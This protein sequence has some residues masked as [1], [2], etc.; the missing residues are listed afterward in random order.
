MGRSLC[1][2]MLSFSCTSLLGGCGTEANSS[3]APATRPVSVSVTALKAQSET[4]S[5]QQLYSTVSR[6]GSSNQGGTVLTWSAAGAGSVTSDGLFACTGLGSAAVTARA[7]SASATT[8]TSCLNSPMPLA[9]GVFIEHSLDFAGPFSSWLNVK[10]MYGAK[11]DGVSDDTAALQAALT[12]QLHMKRVI[13]LPRG[14]YIISDTL[15]VQG[16][17]GLTIIGEDPSNTIIKWTGPQGGTMLDAEGCTWI[18]ISRLTLDGNGSAG[19]GEHISSSNV[20]GFYPTF[21]LLSDQTI[22]NLEVGIEVGSAGE[23]TVERIHFDNDSG[24]GVSQESYNALNF[25]VRD[26]LF[27]E[28]GIGI[29]NA[30]NKD[31]AGGFNVTNSVFVDSKTADMAIGATGPFSIRRSLSVGSHAF[32]TTGATGAPALITFQA[33]TIISP[34]RIPIQIGT[35]SPIVL[36]DNAFA[37]MHSDMPIVSGVAPKPVDIFSVGNRALSNVPFSGNI[38]RVKSIDDLLSSPVSESSVTAPA[39]VYVPPPSTAKVF[40]VPL[41]SDSAA[42]QTLVTQA[43]QAPG[44]GIVHFPA[45]DFEIDQ[46]VVIPEGQPVEVIGDGPAATSL[47]GTPALIGAVLRIDSSQARVADLAISQQVDDGDSPTAEGIQVSVP[48]IPSTE[49]LVDETKGYQ[50]HGL[51]VDGIDQAH[52]E[53]LSY[54]LNSE[55]ESVPAS[56]LTGGPILAG[57]S[58]GFGRINMFQAGTDA[59]MLDNNAQLLEEDFWHDAGELGPA[60]SLTGGT[61]SVTVSGASLNTPA[62]VPTIT[63]NDFTGNIS[64]TGIGSV[65]GTPLQTGQQSEST[66]LMLAASEIPIPNSSDSSVVLSSGPIGAIGQVLNDRVFD[67]KPFPV[68]DDGNSSALWIEQMLSHLR[69]EAPHPRLPLSGNSSRIRLDRIAIGSTRIGIHIEPNQISVGTMPMYLLTNRNG[70]TLDNKSSSSCISEVPSTGNMA[71]IAWT[72]KPG[73]DGGVYLQSAAESLA[74]SIAENQSNVVLANSSADAH[75]EWVVLPVGDGYFNLFNRATGQVLTGR[76]SGACATLSTL[77]GSSEQEW[78]IATDN[79]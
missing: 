37:G 35:P 71:D 44:G 28:C 78:S 58:Y 19:T 14:T 10:T 6:G 63:S 23:I 26:S 70:M 65:V 9:D 61:G 68:G 43:V 29:T 42:I 53:A 1:V 79:E 54:E 39:A 4:N 20:G 8:S 62:S 55:T 36:I 75:Q 60:I 38:G 15:T 45:G 13:W 40:D 17:Y 52:V 16:C 50:D 12:D 69:T 25:W 66:S 51:F 67:N 32:F 56:D 34:G 59:F 31:G 73:M 22:R 24:A 48:D 41:G 30:L 74:A 5:V 76:G 33:N 64:L 57:G 7:G 77:N 2:V 27:T 49:V 21:N 18:H 72:V 47:V 46:Q 11:G 3:A